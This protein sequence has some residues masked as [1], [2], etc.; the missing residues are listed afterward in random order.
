MENEQLKIENEEY[1]FAKASWDF[2]YEVVGKSQ[3]A[4]FR[5]FLNE[6]EAKGHSQHYGAEQFF[7]IL[8]GLNGLESQFHSKWNF[9]NENQWSPKM[10]KHLVWSLFSSYDG[11]SDDIDCL[12]T[13]EDDLNEVEWDDLSHEERVLRYT[14]ALEEDL[15]GFINPSLWDVRINHWA[16]PKGES[17]P[18]KAFESFKGRDQLWSGLCLEKAF[19]S[20]KLSNLKSHF[21]TCQEDAIDYIVVKINENCYGKAMTRIQIEDLT[22]EVYWWIVEN[23]LQERILGLPIFKED[24]ILSNY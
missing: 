20:I 8:K 6:F 24:W 13:E 15:V 1:D 11:I 9:A 14:K 18:F 23:N 12:L 21:E 17:I 7:E 4:L 19:D 10:L 3:E 5:A 2:D 16:S 22:E